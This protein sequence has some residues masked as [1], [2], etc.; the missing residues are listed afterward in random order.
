MW[1][2]N[3]SLTF[4]LISKPQLPLLPNMHNYFLYVELLAGRKFCSVATGMVYIGSTVKWVWTHTQAPYSHLR[5]ASWPTMCSKDSQIP[6]LPDLHFLAAVST[7]LSQEILEFNLL[8]RQCTIGL[9][10]FALS[11][12]GLISPSETRRL[13]CQKPPSHT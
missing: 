12:W 9:L 4:L 1:V 13:F 3:W 8:A 5:K 2:F 6:L 7:L 10:T 11:F